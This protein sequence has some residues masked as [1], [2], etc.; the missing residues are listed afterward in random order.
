[1]VVDVRVHVEAGVQEHREGLEPGPVERQAALRKERIVDD[2][3]DVDRPHRDTAHVGVAQHVVHVVGREHAR[4][5]RLEMRQPLRVRLERLGVGLPHQV[6]D[7]LRIDGLAALE[8]AA[9]AP[10]EAPEDLRQ[11]LA[12]DPLADQLV[13]Q[14][15]IDQEV[16]VE[17][18]AEG[19]VA[20]V[21]DQSRR[22]QELLDQRKR[23]RVG[24]DR[25][26]RRIELLGEASGEVHRPERVLEAAVL[27]RGV[28]PARRLE[29]GH[30]AQPL[31]PR[32]VDQVLLGRLARDPA[33][34]GVED[35]LMDG[36][37]DEAASLVRVLGTL[38]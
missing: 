30:A 27:R 14:L 12:D 29:L 36:V 38:H 22:P 26:Q 19:A 2:P 21:V 1:M 25:A 23:G 7:P 3:I 6:A 35:V 34:A 18:V 33:R 17:E 15:V 8:G 16:V 20:D 5:E 24:K 31:H 9:R 4:E 10:P 11:L 28:H 37:G 32:R 13:G